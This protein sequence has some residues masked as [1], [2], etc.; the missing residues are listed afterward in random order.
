MRAPCPNETAAAACLG[1]D[2]TLPAF[3]AGPTAVH[4]STAE[5]LRQAGVH[6]RAVRT[7]TTCAARLNDSRARGL[8]RFDVD[9]RAMLDLVSA[10]RAE[11]GRE[12]SAVC[13]KVGGRSVDHAVLIDA[14]TW[15]TTE[16]CTAARAS[17]AVPTV[18]SVAF[19][20]DADASHPIVS[21]ASPSA[22]FAGAAVFADAL[23]SADEMPR[24]CV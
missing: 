22:H 18:G 13:G 5:G 16:S 17:Y 20:Q 12:V 1:S 6:L 9:L 21:L 23:P 14:F 15:A 7:V 4:R 11:A 8:S 19:V 3:G 2:V 10:L 24:I